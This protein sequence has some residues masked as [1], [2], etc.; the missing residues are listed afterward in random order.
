MI[1]G[2]QR[3]SYGRAAG[4]SRCPFLRAPSTIPVHVSG[5]NAYSRSLRVPIALIVLGLFLA[6]TGISIAIRR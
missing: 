2:G 3:A 5:G 6:F 4:G 1:G